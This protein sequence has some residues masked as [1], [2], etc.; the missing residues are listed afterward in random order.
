MN[1]EGHFERAV[2]SGWMISFG[3]IGGIV[4]VFSFLATDAPEYH[5]G[6]SVCVFGLC[7]VGSCAIAYGTGCFFENKKRPIARKLH[8]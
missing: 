2:G 7:L 3:N 1:L 8:I 6:Y 4:A 5:T